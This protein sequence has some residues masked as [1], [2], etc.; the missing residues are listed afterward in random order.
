MKHLFILT[1]FFI[2]N[3]VSAQ[4]Y[5]QY[6]GAKFNSEK[7]TLVKM[8]PDTIALKLYFHSSHS[9]ACESSE[10]Y[11][12]TKNL[13]GD[14][15]VNINN[16]ESD[17][18]QANLLKGK[19]TSIIIKS[20]S[21]EPCCNIPSGIFLI[22]PTPPSGSSTTPKLQSLIVVPERFLIYW[23]NFQQKM[24]VKDSIINNIDFPYAIDLSYLDEGEVSKSEFDLNGTQIFVNGNAFITNKFSEL[25]NPKNKNL[26]IGKYDG[27]YMSEILSSNFANKFGDLEQIYVVADLNYYSESGGYKAYFREK[28]GTFK[29]IGFEGVEQGD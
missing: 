16:S 23:N 28:N 24:K 7:I 2:L 1:F 19:V 21:Y 20:Q 27:G 6:E 17:Y 10:I 29:F 5:F 11:Y 26:F 18:I 12:L 15:I 9:C 14:F 25:N 3:I 8:S 22:K 4:N 13:I